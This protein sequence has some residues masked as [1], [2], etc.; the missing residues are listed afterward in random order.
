VLVLSIRSSK[1]VDIVGRVLTPL[2]LLL[3]IV[4][5]V[6]GIVTPIGPIS[7]EALNQQV[8][9]NGI[10]NGYQ[11]MD[12][13]GSV[14]L[15]IIIIQ[16]VKDKGYADDAA[17]KYKIV[18]GASII[19]VVCLTVVY[20]GLAY[21]GATAGSALPADIAQAD[22]L[23]AVV[24]LLLGKTGSVLLGIIVLLACLTTAIGLASC[25]GSYF[26]RVSHGK[27]K[28]TVCVVVC[29]IWSAVESNV[30]LSTI[31]SLAVPVLLFLY[32]IVLVI[33]ITAFFTKWIKNN[34]VVKGAVIF[35]A[36]TSVLTV[37]QLYGWLDLAFIEK[38]PLYGPQLNWVI[39]AIIGGI[40]GGLI[41]SKNTGT[42]EA[43]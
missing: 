24:Q 41:K 35:A 18:G 9:S 13:F 30:G 36:I 31:I 5:I 39:P 21:I 42:A 15:G 11:T 12:G 40:I 38:M 43:A 20:G 27:I 6:K 10:I 28:Y 2:L 17:G 4:L 26:E 19:A 8:I 7:A 3:L 1:V 34:N 32:P 22:L 16:A 37:A 25:T 29:I 14:I 23:V 33:I